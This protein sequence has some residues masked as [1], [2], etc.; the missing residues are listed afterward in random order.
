MKLQTMKYISSTFTTIA[1]VLKEITLNWSYCVWIKHCLHF[2]YS[3]I[4]TNWTIKN[5]LFIEY[6]DFVLLF[7]PYVYELHAMHFM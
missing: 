4:S 7:M 2:F 5:V 3:S 6:N 1:T